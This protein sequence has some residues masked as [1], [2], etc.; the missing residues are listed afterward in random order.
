MRN[1]IYIF[2]HLYDSKSYAY[3]FF[4]IYELQ[5]LGEKN[6]GRSY[7]PFSTSEIE[8]RIFRNTLMQRNLDG[9]DSNN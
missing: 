7:F 9:N 8:I 1:S 3:S 5:L 4:L 6:K 2:S